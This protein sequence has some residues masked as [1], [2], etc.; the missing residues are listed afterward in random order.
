[1][2]KAKKSGSLSNTLG[3]GSKLKEEDCPV[4]KRMRETMI[5]KYHTLNTKKHPKKKWR[6]IEFEGEQVGFINNQVPVQRDGGIFTYVESNNLDPT[7][8]ISE[9]SKPGVRSNLL[10]TSA[11]NSHQSQR[12]SISQ[13]GK[14]SRVLVLMGGDRFQRAL[15][16]TFIMQV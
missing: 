16:D 2:S 9:T 7:G 11:L 6:K 8:N 10:L 14:R 12:T 4:S 15:N 3:N 1:M 13:S 5:S